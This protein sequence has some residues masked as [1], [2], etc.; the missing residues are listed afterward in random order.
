M[1][2]RTTKRSTK[3]SIRKPYRSSAATYTDYKNEIPDGDYYGLKHS[4]FKKPWLPASGYDEM[5][6]KWDFPLEYLNPIHVD[7]ETPDMGKYNFPGAQPVNPNW[8][9]PNWN[10]QYPLPDYPASKPEARKK[11]GTKGGTQIVWTYCE[12]Q[13][14][15]FCPGETV[16]VQFTEYT[17]DRIESVDAGEGEIIPPARGK[18]GESKHRPGY[19]E[20]TYTVMVRI[21]EAAGMEYN[22][23]S[24]TKSGET[25]VSH[26]TQRQNCLDP[27]GEMS[28]G[29]TSAQMMTGTSQTLTVQNG[30]PHS[31]Y[32]Y[33]LSGG[34]TLKDTGNGT[35]QY[36]APDTNPNCENNPTI[37]VRDKRTGA[38]CAT[39]KMGVSSAEASGD[40]YQINNVQKEL[41]E[42]TCR[43]Q[44]SDQ[45]GELWWS[46][47]YWKYDCQGVG[48]PSGDMGTVWCWQNIGACPV[49]VTCRSNLSASTLCNQGPVDTRTAY[50]KQQGCCPAALA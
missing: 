39:L 47:S 6:Y 3:E 1:N 35:M 10:P 28:I 4:E 19:P 7:F 29:Y 14:F 33:E 31:V 48:T 8:N 36:T 41:F 20:G 50:Q 27:C 15:E 17:T 40:A 22:V 5:E 30:D 18:L 43:V 23:T 21:P 2:T 49:G 13:D 38:V 24:T 44:G 11:P 9:P 34:G 25:C 12:G 16:A 45:C 26:G 32:R 37:T 42:S 46:W